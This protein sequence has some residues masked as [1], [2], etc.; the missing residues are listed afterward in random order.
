MKLKADFDQNKR[1]FGC[2][3][4]AWIMPAAIG[5][6]KRVGPFRPP[7]AAFVSANRMVVLEDSIDHFPCSFN[8]VLAREERPVALHCVT[9]KPF[10][11]RFLSRLFVTKVKLSLFSNEFLA[12]KLDA[13]SERDG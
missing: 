2:A 1:L 9:Q 11:R 13:D 6:D 7:G 3:I 8:R 5:G 4:G 12:R 10:V